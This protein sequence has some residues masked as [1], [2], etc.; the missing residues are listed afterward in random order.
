MQQSIAF[1]MRPA[2]HHAAGAL[3]E[4]SE[5]RLFFALRRFQHRIRRVTVRIVDLNGPKR[6]VDSRCAI[7]LDLVD[8]HRV[9]AEAVTPWPFASVT[10]AAGRLNRAVRDLAPRRQRRRPGFVG[11]AEHQA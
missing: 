6:G 8:G 9:I 10:R 1:V 2:D 3:R 4:H 7:T 11:V 5:R